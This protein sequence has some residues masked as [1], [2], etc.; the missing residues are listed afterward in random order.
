MV[1]K[2]ASEPVSLKTDDLKLQW[3]YLGLENPLIAWDCVNICCQL[4]L[5][6]LN[7]PNITSHCNRNGSQQPQL[8]RDAAVKYIL[9]SMDSQLIVGP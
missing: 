7:H 4:T 1:R 2:P 3:A 8:V 5:S 9:A 6:T